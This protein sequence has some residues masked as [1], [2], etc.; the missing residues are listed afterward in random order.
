V[1]KENPRP[2]RGNASLQEGKPTR[3]IQTSFDHPR[4]G[5][6]MTNQKFF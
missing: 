2:L 3:A 4:M 1:K 6:P 5:K